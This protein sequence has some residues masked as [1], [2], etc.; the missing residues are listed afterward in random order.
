MKQKKEQEMCK[1]EWM[2]GLKKNRREEMGGQRRKG[3]DDETMTM[4][5]KGGESKNGGRER[6]WEGMKRGRRENRAR[7]GRAKRRG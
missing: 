4:S 3:T 5:S 7:Q 6:S 2:E 1:K